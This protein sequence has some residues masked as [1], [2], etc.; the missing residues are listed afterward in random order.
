M[1]DLRSNTHG[2]ELTSAKVEFFYDRMVYTAI[3]VPGQNPLNSRLAS[4][5]FKL[6]F[7]KSFNFSY[8]KRSKC[9][10]VLIISVYKNLTKFR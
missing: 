1:I 3:N 7:F 4:F 6:N 5:S 8:K 2:C 9:Q 10:I